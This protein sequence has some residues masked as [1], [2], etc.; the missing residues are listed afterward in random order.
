MKKFLNRRQDE[1]VNVYMG[2]WIASIIDLM[3]L[4]RILRSFYPSDFPSY[5]SVYARFLADRPFYGYQSGAPSSHFIYLHPT[6]RYM[7]YPY[8]L[9]ARTEMC[10]YS[11]LQD[12]SYDRVQDRTQNLYLVL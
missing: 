12:L 2:C 8:I 11:G 10:Q 3:S 7:A 6:D 5:C 1:V 9:N 4:T